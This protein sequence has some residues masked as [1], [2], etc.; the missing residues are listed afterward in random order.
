MEQPMKQ[1]FLMFLRGN[2][3]YYEDTRDGGQHSLHTRDKADARRLINAKNESVHNPAAVNLQIGRTYIAASSPE[4]LIRTWETVFEAMTPVKEGLTRERWDRVGK[5]PA[6]NLI[7]NRPI[8]ETQP[9]EILKVL[10]TGTIATNVFLRRMHNYAIDMGWL[11]TPIIAKRKWPKLKHGETRAITA[12][13]HQL[14]LNGEKNPERHDYYEL[15]WYLGGSQGDIAG[16]QAE[17]ANV[18]KGTVFYQRQKTAV[19]V[20]QRMG[21]K[22]K[23]VLNRLPKTVGGGVKVVEKRRFEN[24]AGFSLERSNSAVSVSRPVGPSSDSWR[25]Q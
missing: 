23:E 8:M 14:I 5:D 1:T 3:Y 9:E 15:L 6:Y 24:P 16:L 19:D 12:G 20:M 21:S 2:V 4:M 22:V 10:K 13:E 7:W 17:D 18:E 11:P 25:L